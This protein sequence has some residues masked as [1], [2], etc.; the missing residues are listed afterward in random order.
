[1]LDVN[2]DP[3]LKICF[4]YPAGNDSNLLLAGGR[5]IFSLPGNI[6]VNE[7]CYHVANKKLLYYKF[8][9]LQCFFVFNTPPPCPQLPLLCKSFLSFVLWELHVVCHNFKCLCVL[10]RVCVRLFATPWTVAFQAS[11]PIEFSRQQQGS[12]VP[13]PTPGDHPNPGIK[14]M[15]SCVYCIGR[16]IL[17][18]GAIWD[19]LNSM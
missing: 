12:R 14:S 16:R 4:V 3:D 1:M 19:T 5:N 13:F 11:L 7:D 15:F 9:F 2:T 17:Y 10:S 8:L 18:P 6:S